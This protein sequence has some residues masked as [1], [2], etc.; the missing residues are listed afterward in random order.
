MYYF[1]CVTRKGSSV[2]DLKVRNNFNP[3][4]VIPQTTLIDL[5]FYKVKLPTWKLLKFFSLFFSK[6]YKTLG[7]LSMYE[8]NFNDKTQF[9]SL[10]MADDLEACYKSFVFLL[11]LSTYKMRK[12]NLKYSPWLAP[13]NLLLKTYTSS[14]LSSDP[15]SPTPPSLPWKE[16]GIPKQEGI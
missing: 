2:S 13:I 1:Q 12:K 3:L 7:L 11:Q 4:W 8:H 6:I 16:Q 10:H 14:S 5:T 15:V 9:S